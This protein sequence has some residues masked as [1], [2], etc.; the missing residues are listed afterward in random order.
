MSIVPNK[1]LSSFFAVVL[2][3]A[4]SCTSWA[5][6]PTLSWSE[7]IK[8]GITESEMTTIL[9]SLG[10]RYFDGGEGLSYTSSIKTDTRDYLFCEDHL[11]AIVEGVFTSGAEFNEWFDAFL[12]THLRHGKPKHYEA[13]KDWGRFRAEWKLND[14]STLYFQLQSNLKDKHGWSRQLYS[15]NTGSPCLER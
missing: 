2:G 9:S 10:V 1:V 12:A 4:T 8:P 5:E 13:E 7:D 15:R 6:L 14:G 11:Y 3:V